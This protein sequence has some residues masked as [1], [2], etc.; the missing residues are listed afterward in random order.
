MIF[1]VSAVICEYNPFHNGHKYQLE[2]MRKESDAVICIMSGDF[3]QRGDAAIYDKFVRARAA[4]ASGA[5]LVIMLPVVYSLS[6]AELF[7]LGGVRLCDSFGVVDSLFFGSECGDVRAL[8]KAAE[9]LLKEP[10]EVSDKIKAYLAQGISYPT[11]RAKAFA[12]I[13]DIDI[14]E[15]PNNILAVEYIKALKRINSGITPK[16]IK[17]YSAEHHDT[18]PDG[19]FASATAIRNFAAKDRPFNGFVPESAFELYRN[20]SR[21]NSDNLSQALIYTLRTKEVS[22]ISRINDVG[23]GLENRIKASVYHADSFSGIAEY[24]KSKRYTR[25]KINRILLSVLLDI[26]KAMPKKAP[27]YIRVLGMNKTG[28]AL[29]SDMKQKSTIPIITKTAD[30][31]SLCKS[32]EKDILASDLYTICTNRPQFGQ[33]FKMSPIII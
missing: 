32:F 14:L 29:L 19:E 8:D 31:K 20:E 17:R 26:D 21:A 4:L 24:I 33:D 28:M 13:I 2:C 3:V 10:P 18:E 27:E 15:Q 1:V 23:E 30:Y 12:D 5:D 22:E 25:S 11:A 6:S 7:A 9:I 16:T